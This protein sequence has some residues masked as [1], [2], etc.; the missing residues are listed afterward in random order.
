MFLVLVLVRVPDVFLMLVLVLVPEDLALWTTLLSL[1]QSRYNHPFQVNA[2]YTK[3]LDI[4]A[5]V[6]LREITFPGGTF[7]AAGMVRIPHSGLSRKSMANI[8][9]RLGKKPTPLLIAYRRVWTVHVWVLTKALCQ[10][11]LSE[12]AHCIHHNLNGIQ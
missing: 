9:R 7:R 2:C 4:H 5:R 1:P 8:E 6:A 12:S 3:K 10:T 11:R